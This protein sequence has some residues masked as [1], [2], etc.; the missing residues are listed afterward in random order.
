MKG[1]RAS[2]LTLEEF[3]YRPELLMVVA[4]ILAILGALGSWGSYGYYN[5]GENATFFMGL[6][7]LYSAAINLGYADILEEFVPVPS[8]SAICGVVTFILAL[9][10]WNE[11]AGGGWGLYL[12]LFAGLIA[13]FA[14][15]QSYTGG[16]KIVSSGRAGL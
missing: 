3:L 2:G 13:M 15:F 11:P 10:Y 6:I 1:R 5:G 9:S 8:T 16:R 7:M 12:T 4:G 14:A